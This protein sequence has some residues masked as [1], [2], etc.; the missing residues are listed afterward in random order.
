MDLELENRQVSFTTNPKVGNIEGYEG[1]DS[2]TGQYSFGTARQIGVVP[3]GV[4]V[5]RRATDL[6]SFSTARVSGVDTTAAA[7]EK[8]LWTRWEKSQDEEKEAVTRAVL[9]TFFVTWFVAIFIGIII[10]CCYTR[11][12]LARAMAAGIKAGQQLEMATPRAVEPT[13]KDEDATEGV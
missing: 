11:I 6:V 10:G 9:I 4:E 2:S 8:T 12:A 5:Q 13:K 7:E 3:E 1:L